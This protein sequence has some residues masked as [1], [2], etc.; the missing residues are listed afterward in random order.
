MQNMINFD[1]LKEDYLKSDIDLRL[2]KLKNK[3]K[4]QLSLQEYMDEFNLDQVIQ[5]GLFMIFK[6]KPVNTVKFLGNF[7]YNYHLQSQ[8]EKEN[9]LNEQKDKKM[10]LYDMR[11][12]EIQEQL[13]K[14]EQRQL[15]LKQD[16]IMQKERKKTP[17]EMMDLQLS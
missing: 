8:K 6:E 12:S 14:I 13:K 15:E 11:Q 4:D 9:Y 2:Q 1:E 5:E 3:I 16:T 10:T 7:F 17:L